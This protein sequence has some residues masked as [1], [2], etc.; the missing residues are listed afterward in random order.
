VGKQNLQ[1]QASSHLGVL[2]IDGLGDPA[3]FVLAA[4][5]HGQAPS[6]LSRIVVGSMD[7]YGAQLVFHFQLACIQRDYGRKS[8]IGGGD[9]VVV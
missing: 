8:D 1:T 5:P 6:P 2:A 7:A 3:G 4:G 9:E